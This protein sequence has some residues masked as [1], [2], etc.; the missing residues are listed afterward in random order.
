MF[1]LSGFWHGAAWNFIAWGAFHGLFLILDRLFLLR[2]SRIGALSIV[3]TFLVTVVGWV[4]FRAE[5]L[6]GGLQY[7]GTMLRLAPAA[8]VA[9]G[10]NEVAPAPPVPTINWL[11]YGPQFWLLLALA[12]GFAFMNALPAL[13]QRALSLYAA[14]TLTLRR[15]VALGLV[16][17]GLLLL[18]TGA[19][20]GSTFNP[21]IY[22]L[23]YTSTRSRAVANR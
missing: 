15:T 21:F 11:Q 9:V 19:I 22:F 18:S 1:I 5:T 4:L 17:A 14:H 13:E 12:A 7:I 2:V 10:W 6:A 20:V 16:A 8:P 23:F 3:P